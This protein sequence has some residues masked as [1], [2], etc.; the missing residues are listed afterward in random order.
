LI[1]APVAPGNGAGAHAVPVAVP[2]PPQ[3]PAPAR[4]GGGKRGGGRGGKRR[5]GA[6]KAEA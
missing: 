5:R 1:S 4:G 2:R 3:R 6:R